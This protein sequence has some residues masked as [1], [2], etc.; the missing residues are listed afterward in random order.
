[1]KRKN[2]KVQYSYRAANCVCL[3]IGALCHKQSLC[4]DFLTGRRTFDVAKSAGGDGRRGA[5]LFRDTGIQ[6]RPQPKT[7]FTDFGLQLY[8]HT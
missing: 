6:P 4:R 1:M 5:N 2:V 3:L 7:A 8:S